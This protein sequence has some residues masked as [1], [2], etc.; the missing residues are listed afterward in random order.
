[1][2]S[3][4]RVGFVVLGVLPLAL[5]HALGYLVGWLVWRLPTKPRRMTLHH[6]ALC[7]PELSPAQRHNLARRSLLQSACSIFELPAIWY[8][9]RWR[10]RRW[11]HQ[12]EA[13]AQLRALHAG[14]K[15]VILLCPH[16]GAW[17]LAGMFCAANG[18]M[19]S[20]YKPQKGVLDT[21]ILEGRERLGAKLVPTE[22]KG[23]KALLQALA[24]HEMIGILPDHDP[25]EGSGVFAPLFGI[26]AHTTAL[27]NKLAARS[28]APVWFCLAERLSWP[29]GFRIHL[30][31][32]PVP[33][34]IA[35]A[36]A[37]AAALNFSIEQV[38]RE[39][40]EQYWWSYKRF[41]RLPPGVPDP[42]QGI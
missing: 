35:D 6:L 19:T 31:P 10:L 41:R 32:M 8:G 18:P 20:L 29:R 26:P 25:P 3:L 15:G 21:L 2:K 1:M 17:E 30:K 7:L 27:V 38:I 36:G 28:G 16:L 40:P 9:P 14:G 33:V 22:G 23:V 4:L 11:L 39:F 34:A 5:M 12:P 24:R 13:Q 37:G 42:Y